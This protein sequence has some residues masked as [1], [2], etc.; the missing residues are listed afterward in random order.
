MFEKASRLKVR[1]DS[2]QGLLTVEDL[3]DVPVTQLNTIAKGLNKKLVEAREEDFLEEESAE[4]EILKLRFDI[5][6]YVLKTKQAGIKAI[7]DQTKKKEQKEKILGI[8]AKKQ[9]DS[10]ENMS[11]DELKKLLAEL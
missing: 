2:T 3:W 9:D 1:F 7:R 6:L 5:V 11:E 4:D 10:L 8:I